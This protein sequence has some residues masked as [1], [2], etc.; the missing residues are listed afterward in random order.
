MLSS[1]SE[2]TPATRWRYRD[3][4]AFARSQGLEWELRSTLRSCV[5]QNALYSI[6]RATPGRIVTHAQGCE[7]WHTL[8]RAFDITLPGSDREDYALLGRA[9]ERMGGVWGGRVS[10]IDDIGHPAGIAKG[11]PKLNAVAA[12]CACVCH[13]GTAIGTVAP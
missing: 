12:G 1:I 4:E 10:Q 11:K 5:E 6:G 3:L 9:W 7:S 8:G 13:T 2:L